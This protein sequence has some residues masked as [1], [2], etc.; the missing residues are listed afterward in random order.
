MP[1]ILLSI[2]CTVERVSAFQPGD[3]L[4]LQREGAYPGASDR[5]W[6]VHVLLAVHPTALFHS[7]DLRARIEDVA[8]PVD[9]YARRILDR[10][11]ND[12]AHFLRY[13]DPRN[14]ILRQKEGG[15]LIPWPIPRPLKRHPTEESPSPLQQ[16]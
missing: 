16:E 10:A 14:Q 2:G 7:S 4:F 9:A 15:E 3:L 8:R 5:R 1:R 13:I 12:P 11:L 6:V